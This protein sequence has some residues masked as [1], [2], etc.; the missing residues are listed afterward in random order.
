MIKTGGKMK[1]FILFFILLQITPYSWA[2]ET[3]NHDL[4]II[5]E[6]DEHEEP[7][8]HKDV[9]E[10]GLPHSHYLQLLGL[11]NS[12]RF[13]LL[14]ESR[15]NN[16]FNELA[17]NPQARNRSPGG[18]CSYRRSYIQNLLK[19]RNIISGKLLISCL[20]NNGR[21]RL[22]DQVSGRFYT[23]SNF[24]DSNIIGVQTSSG[25]DFRVMD[26]QFTSAPMS[27]HKFLSNI[28]ARQK[29]RPLKR[30]GNE[31]GRCYWSITTPYYSY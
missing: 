30:R 28:E 7:E 31:K 5:R 11:M 19:R 24:H 4:S 17:K 3:P 14:S 12:F 1:S 15:A 23:Y 27:L 2:N 26:I 29:I 22:R 25:I 9:S 20:G 10:E 21:L 8:N 18:R 13:T 6:I 16:L